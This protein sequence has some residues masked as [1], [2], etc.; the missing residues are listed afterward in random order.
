VKK[1][2][3]AVVALVLSVTWTC[4]GEHYNYNYTWRDANGTLNITDYA[5]PDNVEIL[6]ISPIPHVPPPPAPEVLPEAK[7]EKQQLLKSAAAL[8]Q[9]EEALR[10]KATDLINEATELRSR[11]AIRKVKRR[12]SRFARRMEDE[13]QGLITSADQAA[14]KAAAL[15]AQAAALE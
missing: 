13:A 4:Y 10:T 9:Q 8:R 14:Q 7:V 12:Y 6:E 3:I 2:S 1:I 15:E 11:D 5:P